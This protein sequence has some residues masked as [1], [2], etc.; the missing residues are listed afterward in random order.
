MAF[1]TGM[2][3]GEVCGRRWRDI[4]PEARPL[5]SIHVHT[6]YQDQPLKTDDAKR[7]RPR[8][9]PIHGE[10]AKV[11][12]RWWAEGWEFVYRHKPTVDDFIV[13]RRD[14]PDEALTES[15]AYKAW[16]AACGAAGVPANTVHESRNTF[17][18]YGRR[19]G[20]RAEVVERITHNAKGSIVDQYT[21]WDWMPLCEAVTC[22]RYDPALFRPSLDQAQIQLTCGSSGWTRTLRHVVSRRKRG[23]LTTSEHLRNGVAPLRGPKR[24]PSTRRFE[25]QCATPNR[26]RIGLAFA[27]LPPSSRGARRPDKRPTSSPSKGALDE[28]QLRALRDR[29]A[30]RPP[31]TPVDGVLVF[32][33]VGPAGPGRW[34]A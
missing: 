21:E 23:S 25:A 10:L 11:L 12:E 28:H 19:C 22:L 1:Y 13:P 9:V 33:R 6:Q 8:K 14:R 2:R 34:E 7:A 17:I 20:A 29:C 32:A 18:S 4:D 15:M 5:W 3:L 30:D 24:T 31:T 26:P 16:I 27:S